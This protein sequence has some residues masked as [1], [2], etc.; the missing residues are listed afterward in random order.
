MSPRLRH[1]AVACLF[2]PGTFVLATSASAEPLAYASGFDTLYRIDLANG[3]AEPIGAFGQAGAGALIGDVEGLALAPDGALFAVSDA[4]KTLLR[5]D[6]ATGHATT[7]GELR[8][9]GQL[10]GDGL[11][12]DFGLA[13]T[14][15]G[16]LWLSSDKTSRLW[17]VTPGTGQ[18]RP[19]GSTGAKLSGLAARGNALYGLGAEGDEAL[20]RVDTSTAQATQV[21]RLAA[22]LAYPDAGLDFDAAGQL[23]AVLDFFPPVERSDVAR[24]DL[25]TGAVTL[26][27]QITGPGIDDRE[28]ESIA[29]GPPGGCGGGQGSIGVPLEVPA[30]SPSGIALLAALAALFGSL[31]LRRRS[32]A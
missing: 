26:G 16:R 2:F 5:V 23:W 28:I 19:V 32:A 30:S 21:G 8:E 24:I 29:I 27:A 11:N 3:K 1:F 22:G 12:L 6:T 14:C 9:S 4:R 31:V 15:D 7:I 20:Y 18:V 10:I 13:Y 17:E 25:A